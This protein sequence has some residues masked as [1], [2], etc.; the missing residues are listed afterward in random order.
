MAAAEAPRPPVR[1]SIPLV[2]VFAFGAVVGA[3][4]ALNGVWSEY[5]AWDTTAPSLCTA[6]PAA[7]TEAS[8]W[9]LA[10]SALC[11]AVL[12]VARYRGRLR[13]SRSRRLQLAVLATVAVGIA[14]GLLS[15]LL[16][17]DSW[18]RSTAALAS[19]TAGGMVARMDSPEMPTR[20]GGRGYAT[21]KL[22]DGREA[23]VA[24]YTRGV[25]G[26][27]G[28]G[29]G[30]LVSARLLAGD[31]VLL[32]D[33][34][35]LRESDAHAYDAG[36]V[37]IGNVQ[38]RV[39]SATGLFTVY[40]QH[41]VSLTGMAATPG[42][43]LLHGLLLGDRGLASTTGLDSAFRTAGVSHVLAVSGTHLAVVVGM[44]LL[45]GR[46]LGA[47]R[48]LLLAGALVAAVLFAV[49][50]GS[51]VSALRALGMLAVSTWALLSTRRPDPL[52]ALGAVVSVMVLTDP[53]RALSVGLL[54]S[55]S[56]VAGIVLLYRLVN[57]HLRWLFRATPESV[58]SSAA[59]AIV[60]QLSTTPLSVLT[61]GTLPVYGLPANLL[62]VPVS[63]AALVVGQVAVIAGAVSAGAGEL[64][65]SGAR[66]LAG[67][68]AT[69]ASAVSAIP[70]AQVAVAPQQGR[71]TAVAVLLLTAALYVWWPVHAPPKG[72]CSRAPLV[73]RLLAAQLA[74]RFRRGAAALVGAG[75]V[76][77]LVAGTVAAVATAHQ[78]TVEFLDVGQGDAVLVRSGGATALIDTGPDPGLLEGH[79]ALRGIRRIDLLI[80]THDHADHTGGTP[81]AIRRM[82][83][84]A[85]WVAMGAG[86]SPVYRAALHQAVVGAAPTLREVGSGDSARIGDLTVEVLAPSAPVRD[87]SANDSCL[88]LRVYRTDP[89]H[90]QGARFLPPE[91]APPDGGI[92][93]GGDA[94]GAAT[95][96]AVLP[97][98]IWNV[99]VL[100][101]GHHGSADSVTTEL[102][103]VLAPRT[104][105]ISVGSDNE[106][107][108]P[109]ATVLDL[110]RR[111]G[112]GTL[113]TD[114]DGS[115]TVRL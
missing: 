79:L 85:V 23:R 30:A 31:H 74:G 101:V 2:L 46:R 63:S 94:E 33:I 98:G 104:A 44:V 57:Y 89:P 36:A 65:M 21:V 13:Q 67:L 113:R 38:D 105:V 96:R 97:R 68:S 35:P 90:G 49:A 71:G 47:T 55:A 88:I 19:S 14:S 6:V 100:K 26:K 77:A 25:A 10:T 48:W 64:C 4:L 43:A 60:A 76:T 62:I 82:R 102:L 80:L 108:H 93:I 92:I 91:R 12:I 110:L 20:Y 27:A 7:V 9:A 41:V 109:H 34:R 8:A 24:V 22:P 50:T 16:A 72:A 75:I 61:F 11:A 83:S 18:G 69:V 86:S 87:P 95:L 59:V 107:G 81:A 99:D 78:S 39:S 73:S 42:T 84:G 29:A 54:L 70:G 51:Q 114:R 40:R 115:V 56:A 112:V 15:G 28:A 5:V 1:P 17:G 52:A 66:W 103:S 32:S 106:Y 37:A 53:F 111:Y 58:A 45:A 3:R